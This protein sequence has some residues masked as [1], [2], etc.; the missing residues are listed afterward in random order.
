[1]KKLTVALLVSASL[2]VPSVAFSKTVGLD[3]LQVDKSFKFQE[4]PVWCWAATIQMALNYYGFNI[5]QPDIVEKTFG[6]AI[7]STGNWMQMTNNLN[8]VG[9]ST[10]GKTIM[11][12]ATVYMGS[13]SSE[14]VINH[15]KQKKPVIM[16]FNNPQTF[17]G[18]AVLITGVDYKVVGN[19]ATIEKLMIRDPF[20]YNEAH[21]ANG[22]KIVFPNIINPTN[23]WL[24]DA[25]EE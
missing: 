3:S 11:V 7:S 10:N 21:V 15:L 20:P 4:T 6:A 2:I 14:A 24:V 18:H 22:G 16:A 1:M 9:K 17:T 5:S 23:M 12:S 19:R 25:T 13:P 8:F